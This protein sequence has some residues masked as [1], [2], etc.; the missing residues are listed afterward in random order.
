MEKLICDCGM[1]IGNKLSVWKPCLLDVRQVSPVPRLGNFCHLVNRKRQKLYL[2]F[3]PLP[4]HQG[5]SKFLDFTEQM[6]IWYKICHNS[7]VDQYNAEQLFIF[8]CRYYY[9]YIVFE[10][11]SAAWTE[12][13][14]GI[15][16]RSWVVCD[17]FTELADMSHD[18]WKICTF[19]GWLLE[20]ILN[21][22]VCLCLHNCVVPLIL[23]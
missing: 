6:L 19:L 4:L 7:S 14:R 21:V 3:P 22:T 11:D 1:W 5:S 15:F 13:S 20:T 18:S 9:R 16:D 23:N 12:V 17:I 8:R 10:S 2:Y